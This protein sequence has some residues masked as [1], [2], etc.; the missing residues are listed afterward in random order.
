VIESAEASRLVLVTASASSGMMLPG[1]SILGKGY[2]VC[3]RA[4]SAI[5]DEEEKAYTH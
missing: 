3:E 5:D 1:D 2:T 4:L